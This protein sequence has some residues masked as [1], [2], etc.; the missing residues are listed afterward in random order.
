MKIAIAGASGYTGVELF[1]VLQQYEDLEIN[2]ITSRTYKGKALKE[3]FPFFIKSKYENLVFQE[4]FEFEKSDIY[5]L[6]LPHEPS[7]ELVYQLYKLGKKVIDLSAAYRIKELSA[8]PECYGF[9]HSHP[10]ILE[11]AVYGLP[12]I[13]R[14]E[15]KSAQIIA[16]PGCY[17]TATLLGLYPV[18]KENLNTENTVIVNALSGISGAGRKLKED[19]HYPEAFGNSYAYSPKNHRHIPEMENVLKI[20]TDKDIKIRFTPH[21]LPVAR[22]MISTISVK[23]DLNEKQ[24]KELFYEFYKEEPFIRLFDIPSKIKN[25]AGTNFCDIFVSKDDRTGY[26]VIISVIDNLGK[27]ASLQAIQNFNLI[28]EKKETEHL[29]NFPV[30]P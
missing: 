17:P 13:F 11:K 19:F 10:D 27:G 24:L 18:I 4:N 3:V 2:Q 5:F 6:C 12:E 1:K 7:I 23:T 21:I 14:N 16:N 20:S 8:Y 22:G 26:A 9:E 15:I 25:V 28:T 30:W 29:I